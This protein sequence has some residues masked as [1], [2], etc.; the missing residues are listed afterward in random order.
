MSLFHEDCGSLLERDTL[1]T[2]DGREVSIGYC[3][4]C[5]EYADVELGSE[6]RLETAQEDEGITEILERYDEDAL[7]NYEF[8]ECDHTQAIEHE[9]PAGRGDEDNLIMYECADCG[10]TERITSTRF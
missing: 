3:E 4:D 2:E 7:K 5:D 10:N 8:R 1:E 9:F 6:W